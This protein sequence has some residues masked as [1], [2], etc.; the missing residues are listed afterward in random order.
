MTYVLG[1]LTMKMKPMLDNETE[2]G[3]PGASFAAL[4]AEAS[5]DGDGTRHAHIVVIEMPRAL[6]G[7]GRTHIV[8]QQ[9][10]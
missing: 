9:T 1:R 10:D 6:V 8:H 3:I 4:T 7:L 5:L 2:S